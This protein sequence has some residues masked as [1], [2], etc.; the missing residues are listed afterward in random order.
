MSNNKLLVNTPTFLYTSTLIDDEKE[1]T[2][3][4]DYVMELIRQN[5]IA[6][7]EFKPDKYILRR[8]A[9]EIINAL[10]FRGPYV[11]KEVESLVKYKD[12]KEQ[13]SYYYNMLG[14]TNS[15]KYTYNH[16]LWT[17]IISVK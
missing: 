6:K 17:E 4:K 7:Y 15:Y 13:T 14:A 5:V 10:T 2:P 9:V 11:E 16:N 12:L 3:K 8:E 1:I